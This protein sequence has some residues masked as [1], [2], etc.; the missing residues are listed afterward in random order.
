MLITLAIP[1]EAE[2]VNALD[3]ALSATTFHRDDSPLFACS[4]A[5]ACVCVIRAGGDIGRFDF[6]LNDEIAV[7]IAFS[8]MSYEKG[9]A[10]TK[11]YRMSSGTSVNRA[12]S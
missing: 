3:H 10:R 4:P 1:E 8:P 5:F 9:H 7:S 2:I 11:D 6:A 12:R